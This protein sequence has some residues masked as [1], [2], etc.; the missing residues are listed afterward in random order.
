MLPPPVYGLPCPAA[1]L[2]GL[3]VACKKWHNLVDEKLELK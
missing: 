3:V 2:S 1:L